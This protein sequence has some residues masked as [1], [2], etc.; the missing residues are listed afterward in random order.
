MSLHGITVA[1]TSSRRASELANLVRKFRGIPYIAPTIG[2]KNNRPLNSECNQFIESISNE[3][4]H[5]FI[6]M[7]GVGVFNLFQNI[8]RSQRLNT[9]HERL[10]DTIVIARSNKPEME[11]RKFGIKTNFV[12]DINTL[13]GTLNLMKSFDVKNKNIGILW[14]GDSSDSFKKKLE[15]LG[16][17]VF[18]FSS[19]SYSSSLEHQNAT[20]LKEMGYDYVAPNEEKIE[21]LIEDLM[22]GTV[23]SITFT[24]PPAVKEFFELAKRNNRFDSLKDM[25][26]KNVLVVSVGPSTSSMLAQFHVLVDIMPNTYRMGPMIKELADYISSY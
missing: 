6:F 12:P 2:I 10:Q 5:F 9:V 19:Y 14:H 21:G 1:I 11:L 23:D 16:A 15:S 8:Q 18:D 22:N 24:S 20:I 13:E 25:L 3:K 26:N 4:M 17:N 7:T